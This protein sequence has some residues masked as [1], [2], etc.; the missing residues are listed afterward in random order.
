MDD[1]EILG[2]IH[3]LVEQE[4]ALRAMV[5]RGELS[6]EEEN[7][8]LRAVDEE[9]DQSWDLLRRRRAARRA[10]ADPDAVPARPVSEV[11]SYLQ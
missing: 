9:L 6:T 1:R 5:Q 10:G 7:T 4:H 3:E 2:R 8:R 11:E